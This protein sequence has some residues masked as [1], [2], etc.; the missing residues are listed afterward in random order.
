M[1][2]CESSWERRVYKIKRGQGKLSPVKVIDIKLKKLILDVNLLM[3][4][5]NLVQKEQP[6]VPKPDHTSTTTATKFK[7]WNKL[8]PFKSFDVE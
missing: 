8:F 3:R 4:V 7:R 1:G 2:E 5:K 6:T